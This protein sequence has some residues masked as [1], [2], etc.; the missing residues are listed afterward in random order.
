MK[1]AVNT[2]TLR[3][4][5]PE[6]VVTIL[7]DN[8]IDAVEWAGDAH[9]PPGNVQIAAAVK[10]LCEEKGM[11]CISLGSY[12]QCDEG[13]PGEGPFR[14]DHGAGAVLDSAKAL[15]VPAIRIWAGRMGSASA[16]P[17]Y[18]E[19]V[20]R[21]MRTFCDQEKAL[22]MT[23]HLEFHPNTLTDTVESALALIGTVAKENLY[24]YWQPRHGLGVKDNL[25]DIK[26]LEPFLSHVHVFHWLLQDDGVTKQRLPLKEGK[27]RWESYF[28]ALGKLTGERY[29][30]I[31]F[32]KDDAL[33]QLSEDLGVL[34]SII[35]GF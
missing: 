27:E 7:S 25:A 33:S 16:S 6:E 21:C 34:R 11:Q 3:A 22:G 9:V 1:L 18:R 19:E 32:V 2:F 14:F 13:G 26:A 24:S 29:A 10:S 28:A 31:E 8:N 15:G 12:Y 20:A 35:C 30:M 5:F 23:V 4:Y 17:E